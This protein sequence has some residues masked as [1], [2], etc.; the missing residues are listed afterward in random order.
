RPE[1]LSKTLKFAAKEILGTC[2]SLGVTVEGKDPKEI[3]RD[4][5]EGK[6]DKIFAESET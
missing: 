4:I 2:V 3:M 6:Y 1:L 5:D